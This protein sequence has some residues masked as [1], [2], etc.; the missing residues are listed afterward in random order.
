MAIENAIGG[1]GLPSSVEPPLGPIDD[2]VWDRQ[3]SR[4]ANRRLTGLAVA[5][6][7][8]GKLELSELQLERLLLKHREAM[9]HAL[10]LER[11]L[12]AVA[13]ALRLKGVDPIVLK[14][15]ALAH[16]YYPDPSWRP[17]RDL[18]LLVR[19][20]YWKTACSELVA[21]GYERRLPEPRRGFDERFGKAAEFRKDGCEIDLHRTLTV[22]PFGLWIDP[23]EMCSMTETFTLGGQLFNRFN[24][25]ASFI[26]VSMHAA[27]GWRSPLLLTLRDVLQVALTADLELDKLSSLMTRWKLR[28]VVKYALETAFSTFGFE[29]PR[30]IQSIVEG[31]P[32][33]SEA[34]ALRAYTTDRRSRGGTSISTFLA[35]PGISRKVAYGRA[36]LFP[37][38]EF[39]TARGPSQTSYLKRWGVAIRWLSGQPRK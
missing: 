3:C 19:K 27:L 15:P 38:R 11:R 1:F 17:F 31:L 22:G 2:D 14:G 9:A 30:R 29:I 12:V 28:A 24:D 16:S 18:D 35:I 5:C 39:L 8:S 37:D 13:D 23:D 26:N 36:M 33:R 32:P 7:E 21:I 10:E 4:L 20:E 25:L 34:R 6:W